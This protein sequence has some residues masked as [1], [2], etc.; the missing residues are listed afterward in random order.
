M[1]KYRM[2]YFLF[3]FRPQITEQQ[4]FED[5]LAIFLPILKEFPKY[6]YSVECDNSLQ[7]HIHVILFT[8]N[9]KTKD[10]SKFLQLFNKK[11]FIDFKK[12]LLH[13]QTND[14]GFDNR[15]VN[16]T[17]DDLMKVLGYVNKETQCLRRHYEGFT[18]EEVLAAIKFYYASEHISKS[19]ISDDWT[20]LTS[21]NA[22]V[23][24]EKY[25][26]DNNIDWNDFQIEHTIKLQMIESKYSYIN[27]NKKTQSQLFNELIIANTKKKSSWH[28]AAEK[29]IHDED[30]NLTYVDNLLQKNSK[31][32]NKL[33]DLGINPDELD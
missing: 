9:P 11:I 7:K 30:T 26:V 23:I 27:F 31:Y 8:D 20:I 33:K 6:S 29:Y 15:K 13:K 3:T 19:Q 21:K 17:Q 32:Y 28:Y 22:H 18:N 16:D 1:L 12:S 5:F 10:N 4:L 25:V 24:I 14:A 2:P